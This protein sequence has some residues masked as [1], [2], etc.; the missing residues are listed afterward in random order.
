M[1]RYFKNQKPTALR[2]RARASLTHTFTYKG[3]ILPRRLCQKN[4]KMIGTT[5][6]SIAATILEIEIHLVQKIEQAVA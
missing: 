4:S 2:P 3:F 1:F 5:S 6:T